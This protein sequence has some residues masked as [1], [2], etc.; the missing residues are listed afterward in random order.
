MVVHRV[1]SDPEAYYNLVGKSKYNS[2]KGSTLPKTGGYTSTT[3][4]R[5]ILEDFVQDPSRSVFMEIRVP[6]GAK[7]LDVDKALKGSDYAQKEW[8][9]PRDADLRVTSSKV[10]AN[11]ALRIR[12]SYVPKEPIE[13]P[14]RSTPVAVERSD[15]ADWA[16]FDE[17]RNKS[18]RGLKWDPDNPLAFY[19]NKI[20]VHDRSAASLAHL[21]ELESLPGGYHER[22]VKH[23]TYGRGTPDAGI[24]IGDKAVPELDEM[25]HLRGV[26]PRGW[27]AG[28]SWDDVPGAYDGNS[29][30]LL[31]GGGRS[32]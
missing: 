26:R 15:A 16:R 29:R 28:R 3:T 23:L 20:V 10:D 17:N 2:F 12:A 18:P 30:K 9:L 31:L 8:L 25:G 32:R 14:T 24:Y 11:G 4:D 21:R 1:V 6:K 5:R 27:E 7:I 22:L 13:V 19:G